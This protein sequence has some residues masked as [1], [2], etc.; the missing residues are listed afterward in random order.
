MAGEEERERWE[1]H[2]REHALEKEG[3]AF[4]RTELDR[5]LHEMNNLREQIANQQVT[6]PTRAEHDQLVSRLTLLETAMAGLTGR[7]TVIAAL[8]GLAVSVVGALVL[9][10]LNLS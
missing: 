2:R 6:Y 3:A 1:A 9:R 5:R 10:A 7:L 4:V 8:S